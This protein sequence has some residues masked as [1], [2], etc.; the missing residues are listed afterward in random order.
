MKF[1]NILYSEKGKVAFITFNRPK[2]LNALNNAL[3]KELKVALDTLDNNENI[4]VLVLSGS[5]EKAF[6]AGADISELQ[7]MDP[8]QGRKFADLGQSVMDKIGALKIPV[9]AAVKGFA[10]GG[11]SEMALSCDFIYAA[12]NA[13]FGLPEVTLGLIPGFGG[14]QRLPRLIGK[15]RA[16]EFILTAKRIKAE[17]AL[18]LG[19]V[20][21][22]CSLEELDSSVEKTA[23]KIA[24]LG[25]WTLSAVKEAVDKG[26]DVDLKS[27]CLIEKNV[28]SLC[29]AT[30][31]AKEGTTAFLEKRPP[32]FE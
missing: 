20:N 3:L 23:D 32:K 8:E 19:L 24:S 21:K 4:R 15:N 27:G 7:S 14:T 5:G 26:M 13:V 31:D 10:L 28:F 12:D 11:G 2:A 29:F 22:V 1:E 25:K 18:E 17:E 6:V 9:I 30:K 16:K